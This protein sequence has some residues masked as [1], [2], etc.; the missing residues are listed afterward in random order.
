MQGIGI[1]FFGL[2]LVAATY[3]FGG[4]LTLLSMVAA[5]ATVF[6]HPPHRSLDGHLG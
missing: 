3:W 6:C 4:A 5:V 2:G 1:F